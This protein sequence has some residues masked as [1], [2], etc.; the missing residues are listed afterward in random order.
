MIN[1]TIKYFFYI[2]AYEIRSY[3]PDF[4]RDNGE[5]VRGAR[6]EIQYR[7]LT[8]LPHMARRLSSRAPTM[9]HTSL[10]ACACISMH[11]PPFEPECARISEGAIFETSGRRARDL[12]SAVVIPIITATI[13]SEF[14]GIS[15]KA[16]RTLVHIFC[17]QREFL[18]FVN[19]ILITS[20][21][22]NR[23]GLG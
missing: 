18:L 1:N 19:S 4:F 13:G 8:A 21:S 5:R 3:F 15:I 14:I 7:G 11:T 12:R 16:A 10:C 20:K 9:V 23:L 6:Y 22:E 2:F 17:G